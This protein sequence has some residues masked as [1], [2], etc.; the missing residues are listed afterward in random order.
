M[1]ITEFQNSL[2]PLCEVN[3]MNPILGVDSLIGMI[4]DNSFSPLLKEDR[5]I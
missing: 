2:K 5:N 4:P 3:G 1:Y